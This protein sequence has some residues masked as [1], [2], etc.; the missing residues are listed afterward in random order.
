MNEDIGRFAE[1]FAK[2]IIDSETGEISLDSASA[3]MLVAG[4]VLTI[5]VN[6]KRPRHL[7]ATKVSSKDKLASYIAG[8]DASARVIANRM[9]ADIRSVQNILDEMVAEGIVE[10]SK[11]RMWR[12]QRVIKYI[13]ASNAS[14]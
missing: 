6:S 8:G 9:K 10:T 5:T 12:G 2:S 3:S 7:G 11:G 13:L 4:R 1:K 14:A